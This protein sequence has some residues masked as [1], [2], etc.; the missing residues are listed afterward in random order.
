MPL[1]KTFDFDIFLS[2]G[3]A[4]TVDPDRGARLWASQLRDWLEEQIAR[5]L[6]RP[7]IYFDAD[8]PR[9]GRIPDDLYRSLERSAV[10]IFAVSP[11]S[12][13]SSSWCQ[14]E[15]AYFWDRA[16]PLTQSAEVLAPEERILKVIQSPPEYAKED[17]PLAL[18]DLRTFELFERT[19]SGAGESTIATDFQQPVPDTVNRELNAL[20][21]TVRNILTRIQEIESA[22]DRRE[23][24]KRVFLGPTFSELDHRRF[25]ELRRELLVSGHEVHSVTPLPIEAETEDEH[26][27]RLERALEGVDL[28]VNFTPRTL[29]RSRWEGWTRNPAA[30][31]L[32]SCLLKS[33]AEKNFQYFCGR[34]R[35]KPNLTRSVFRKLSRSSQHM[36]IKT[37]RACFLRA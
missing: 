17:E 8:A 32:R 27:W 23:S 22:E 1:L 21:G 2:Y 16:R 28:A 4:G 26:R 10:L 36:A 20:Y 18:R 13:R 9:V 15:V 30:Q 12:Y 5:N 31:Q 37:P 19:G 6:A 29:P 35:T 25:R 14:R 7:R 24:G 3:W 33:R 34:I 11:G